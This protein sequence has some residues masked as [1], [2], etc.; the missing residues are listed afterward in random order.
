MKRLL[1][2]GLLILGALALS[3]SIVYG[4]RKQEKA[5]AEIAASPF[6]NVDEITA[7]QLRDYL[8]FVASDEMEGRDTPSRGL[9]ITARFIAMNLSRWG[10][11]PAGDGQGHLERYF[12]RFALTSRRV[13]PEASSAM[14][15]G[16][17]L[18]IG[19][20]FIAAVPSGISAPYP[21]AA[22]G[23]LVYVGHGMMVKARNINAY[24]SVDVKDKIMVVADAYPKGVSF[25]DLR[26][27]AG[28]DFDRPETYAR[29][30]GAKG[31]IFLPSPSTIGFWE[32]RH[33][34]TLTASLP[35]MESAQ[36]A[37]IVPAITISERAAAALF[38]GEKLEFEAV[39]KQMSE[40]A[41][42]ESFDFSEAKQA[43][44]VVGA[45][46]DTILTQN[47]VAVL[48]G[49]D[50]V[51][52]NE[53]VA[54]GAHYDH[55]GMRQNVQ[56]D[57]IWNGADDD[58]SGT[59]AT[60]AIAEALVKGERPKRSFLFVWHAGEE[61]GLWGSEYINHNPPVPTGQIV[62]QLNIDMIGRSRKQ[63]DANVRN[64]NLSGPDEIY[65]IGSKL[66]ST[67][68][69]ALSEEVNASFLKLKFNYK[70]DAPDDPERL[71]YRSDH[72]NYARKGIPIIFYFDGVHEDYH[73]AGDHA[74]KI[75]YEKM[76]KVTRTILAT[77]WKLANLPTRPKVDKPL[78]AQLAEN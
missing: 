50:P 71:F 30:N 44:F 16:Q 68:L 19:E 59:V 57:G 32:Q 31:I 28:V 46:V 25:R 12:Q 2:I 75:D 18:K 74:D 48:E 38:K 36:A 63:G 56:G 21:G 60:M 22:S 41:L 47:V 64:A 15:N 37:R 23:K 39:K 5:K 7:A 11:K 49:A 73:G 4:Q 61:K 69:G 29:A 27:K 55:V 67:E 3:L 77:G 33:Q 35:L 13:L 8:H 78:P 70:Y 17:N 20:D 51:L 52:K 34:A 24:Q 72:Y 10:L 26:G 62:A 1:F 54:I 65:V 42:G 53:Y 40:A 6:G 43:G 45:K 66:M 9:D 76:E 14:I 58:G